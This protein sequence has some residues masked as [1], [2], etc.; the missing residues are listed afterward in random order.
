MTPEQAKTYRFDPFDITKVWPHADFPPID[1]RP[2]GPRPQ[3]GELLRRGR[4]GGVLP[5]ELRPGHRALAG[6]DAP[7]PAVQLPR[8]PPAPAR[9]EL[10]SAPGQRP[11]SG[12]DGEL[13]AGRRHAL[14]RERRAGARTT[15][16]TASAARPPIRAWPRRRSTFRDGRASCLRPRRRRFRP[17]RRAL[18]QGHDGQGP[19]ASGRQHR[20]PPQG[21]QK[22]IQLRQTALFFKA[23]AEY[24][25]RVAKGLGLDVREVKRLAAMSQEERVKATAE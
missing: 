22:R 24:G 7:G 2:H 11:E 5:G 19:R 20:R 3:P 4:A 16:R 8:H 6:Q 10:P 25:E 17:G 9:A 13:S 14:G 21:A 15:G 23:D 1:D 18:P 12:P